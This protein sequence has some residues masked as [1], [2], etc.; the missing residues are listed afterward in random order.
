LSQLVHLVPLRG[1]R[2]IAGK[3]RWIRFTPFLR[4]PRRGGVNLVHQRCYTLSQLIQLVHLVP[5]R[6]NR[7]IAG[8]LGQCV[9]VPP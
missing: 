1:N 8:Q 3:E 5:L 2:W 7:W 9:V 6:G 4:T